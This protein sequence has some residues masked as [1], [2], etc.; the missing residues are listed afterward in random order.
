MNVF[1]LNEKLETVAVVDTYVSLIWTERY[2]E[3]GDFELYTV[4]DP[5]L[6]Y[7][8]RK[9]YYLA[10]RESN[11]TMIIEDIFLDTDIESG[12]YI[13]VTGRSLE[14]IL[15]RRIVWGQRTVAGNF[16]NAI[17]DLLNDSIIS[18]SDSDRKIDNFIFEETADEYITQLTIDAQFTGDNLYDVIKAL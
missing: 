10:L 3:C 7:Y 15:D 6:L 11:S 16:Q 2:S 8:L 9:D 5:I 18:P 17:R 1:V 13:T 12:Q 4:V 14:S